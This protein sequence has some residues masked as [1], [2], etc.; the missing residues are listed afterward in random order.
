[1]ARQ[2]SKTMNPNQ[3][4]PPSRA[5]APSRLTDV[6]WV[7]LAMPIFGVV[8]VLLIVAALVAAV[9]AAKSSAAPAA[10][11]AGAGAKPTPVAPITGGDS[12]VYFQGAK[13][14][15]MYAFPWDARMTAQRVAWPMDGSNQPRTD[16][17]QSPSGR[18]FASRNQRFERGVAT[19]V[20]YGVPNQLGQAWS[21]DGNNVCLAAGSAAAKGQLQVLLDDRRATGKVPASANQTS[22]AVAACSPELDRAV[23]VAYNRY[24][25]ADAWV[26]RFS[27]PDVV[28]HRTYR[29]VDSPNRVVA[30]RD[31]SLL[32][33]G[34]NGKG[35]VIRQSADGQVAGNVKGLQVQG[36]SWTA[37]EVAATADDGREAQLIDWKAGT[38]YWK[39]LPD[40][41]L[42]TAVAQPGGKDV[43]FVLVSASDP[44]LS[45]LWLADPGYHSL[46]MAAGV[47]A[48]FP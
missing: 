41:V 6:D 42:R 47:R 7:R 2:G 21:D 1:M 30:S 12:L 20:N 23:L 39:A 22:V 44:V 10:P 36:F 14:H 17:S 26:L 32:A 16:V 37:A 40:Q 8:A 28:A 48:L 29:I 11:P 33:E 25:A 27:A 31:G 15:R 13:D 9:H 46:E 24:G 43:L 45:D 34:T 5:A 3:M 19:G 4:Q 35:T 38:V 18:L